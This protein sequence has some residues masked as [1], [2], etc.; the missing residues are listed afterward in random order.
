M[1]ATARKTKPKLWEKVKHSITEGDKGGNPGQWS[2]RKAQLATQEYKAEGGGY[3]GG[4]DPDNHLRQWTKEDW[5]TKSGA[6]SK[7]SNERYLPRKAREHLTD[8][9]YAETTA[10]KRKDTREGRQFSRQPAQIASK[11]AKDRTTGSDDLQNR[12]KVDLMKLA[13]QRGLPGR[14]RMNKNDLVKALS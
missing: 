6:K 8:K 5:G 9:E 11:T 2:A 3:E 1:A 10:K 14:S 4:K 12:T 13:A 7:D